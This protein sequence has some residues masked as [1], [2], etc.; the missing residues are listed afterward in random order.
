MN[1]PL[2]HVNRP[3]SS[4]IDILCAVCVNALQLSVVS[5]LLD[6]DGCKEGETCTVVNDGGYQNILCK[7]PT[8]GLY[9]LVAC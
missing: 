7:G 4:C 2:A 9:D 8:T 6:C 1:Q 5:L 3:A